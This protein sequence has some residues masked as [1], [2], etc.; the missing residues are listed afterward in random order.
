MVT[1]DAATIETFGKPFYCKIDVEGWELDVLKGLSQ[2]IPLISFEFHLN[3]K[4][5]TKA[6]IMLEAVISFRTQLPS[7]SLQPNLPSFT[8]K[9]GSY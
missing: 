4:N 9:N 2:P 7:T 1:L 3:G 5:I 6:R 8:P